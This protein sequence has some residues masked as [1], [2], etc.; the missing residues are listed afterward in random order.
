MR[1]S[2]N[3]RPDT[4][5]LSPIKQILPEPSKNVKWIY[6]FFRIAIHWRRVI[7]GSIRKI[8]NVWFRIQG[9]V[10]KIQSPPKD[11]KWDNERPEPR[12]SLFH[13]ERPRR[14]SI[15]RRYRRQRGG[16]GVWIFCSARLW[17]G[18]GAAHACGVA[19]CGRRRIIPDKDGGRWPA[20]TEDKE[21]VR[22]SGYSVAPAY[23]EA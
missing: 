3:T 9:S 4:E 21:T 18:L 11:R 2:R 13:P 6:I 5:S 8:L 17:R 7:Y 12:R 19:G 23:G 20:A 14:R 10:E 16:S 1:Y 22:V 15:A